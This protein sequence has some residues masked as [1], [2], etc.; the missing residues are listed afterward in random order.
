VDRPHTRQVEQPHVLL[1]MDDRSAYD[2]QRRKLEAQGYRVV[3]AAD[4]AGALSLARQSVPRIIFMSTD[5][6]G[7]ERAALL[8]ALRSDDHTRHIPVVAV[9]AGKD[10]SL[11]RLGLMRIHRETW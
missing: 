4:G 1:V 9:S 3:N 2:A 6:S 8:Q 7:S 10:R 5:R 11:E